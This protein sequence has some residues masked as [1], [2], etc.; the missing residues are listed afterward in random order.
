MA[1]NLY[2]INQYVK[3]SLST[4]GQLTD[5]NTSRLHDSMYTYTKDSAPGYGFFDWARDAASAY[6]RSMQ[7]G[8][9]QENQDR[10]LQA[11]KNMQYAKDILDSL[12]AQPQTEDEAREITDA[13]EYA[14]RQ[15]RDTGV[16]TDKRNPTTQE[17]QELIENNQ[18][19][20]DEE[21]KNY[22]HNKEQLDS[23]Y[24][25]YDIS[26]YYTRKS[27]EAVQGWGNML[28]K[29]PATMGT[30]MT[31]PFLQSTSM[32]AGLGGAK[33]GAAAGTAI[34]PGIGT[35]IGAV[36]GGLGGAQIFGGM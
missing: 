21:N 30:S 29:M 26:Q 17:L 24:D 14:I 7:E 27:N 12:S 10:M 28:F 1:N 16:W 23:S 11:R 4:A 20:W 6:Y 9:M 33:F 2:D 8:E 18:K 13:Q 32:A 35:A 34:A 19:I 31:S 36:I 5:T 15:L 22:L 3:T 25:N